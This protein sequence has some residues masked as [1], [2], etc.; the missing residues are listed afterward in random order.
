[1]GSNRTP[2][3]GRRTN[4]PQHPPRQRPVLLP[5]SSI[6]APCSSAQGGPA[7]PARLRAGSRY[8]T[9]P[10]HKFPGIAAA[11]ELTRAHIKTSR[12]G[13]NIERHG[14]QGEVQLLPCP[15]AAPTLSAPHANRTPNRGAY[16]REMAR[17]RS[18]P[19]WAP[20]P[21]LISAPAPSPPP[22][23]RHCVPHKPAIPPHTGPTR[24][25]GVHLGPHT[26]QQRCKALLQLLCVVT[27]CM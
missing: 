16:L 7:G 19:G 22:P 11:D 13:R 20:R 4:G 17:H 23:L 6:P 14:N 5:V 18:A 21:C 2:F 3:W 1:L 27:P 9:S 25:A 8:P 10:A 26:H 12:P 24:R 15:P